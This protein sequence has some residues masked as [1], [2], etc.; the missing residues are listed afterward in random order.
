LQPL[1]FEM[2]SAIDGQDAL[3]KLHATPPDLILMDLSMPVM[4][5]LEATR[6]IRESSSHP[7]LPIIALSANASSADRVEALAA[8]ASLFMSKPFERLALI[9]SIGNCLSL[10]W[11]ALP[12]A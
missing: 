1:G 4:D 8:G 3:E 10:T 11:T 9:H 6:R 5:G 7:G 12:D 2:D